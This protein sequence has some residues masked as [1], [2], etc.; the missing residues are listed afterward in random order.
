MPR[1][2]VGQFSIAR[3]VPEVHSA[4]IPRPKSV[5][6]TRIQPKDG[7]NATAPSHAANQRME[8]MSGPLRPQRSD[9][10]PAMKPPAR[11][12]KSVSVIEPAVA[13]LATPNSRAMLGITSMKIVKSNASRTHPAHAAPKA[14]HWGRVGSLHHE[15]V[16]IA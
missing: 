6:S 15:T 2:R 12:A 3:V 11:R 10:A 16:F 4:P 8:T 5:R 14:H 13:T 9:A 7:A 1:L